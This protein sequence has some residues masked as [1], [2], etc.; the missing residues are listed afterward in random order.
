MSINKD[1]PNLGG[2]E[3]IACI[4]KFIDIT[5]LVNIDIAFCG[6]FS[7]IANANGE[8]L[9]HVEYCQYQDVICQLVVNE[10]FKTPFIVL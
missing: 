8:F 2:R 10:F 9:F 1:F 3:I 7:E 5:C 6:Y 4:Y